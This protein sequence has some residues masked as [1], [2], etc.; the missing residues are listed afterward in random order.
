MP[1]S[2]TCSVVTPEQQVFEGEVSYTVVPAWDGEMGFAV[3]RAP[4]LLQVGEGRLRLTETGGKKTTLRVS[5]GFAQM[6]GNQL[7]V[8]T[9]R[10][11]DLAEIN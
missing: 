6:K 9:D 3:N 8:L 11:D 5:G 4:I 10:A 2:Y 1:G 7:T